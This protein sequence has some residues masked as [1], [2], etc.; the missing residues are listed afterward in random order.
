M[1]TGDIKKIDLSISSFERMITEGYLYVD[2]TR[3]IEH[4]LNFTSSVQLIARQRRLG[5]SLNMDMLRCF[6]T[7][8]KDYRHLFKGLYIESSPMWDKAHTGPVFSFDFKTL[9]AESYKAQIIGQTYKNISTI[10][11]PD[12]LKGYL[13]HQFDNLINNPDM[14]SDSLLILTEIAYK[15]TGKRSYLLIDEYD[16]LLMYHYDKEQYEE[17]RSFKAALLSAGLK[18]NQYLE[19]ALLTGVM[20]ISHESILSGLNNIVTFDVFRDEI[21]TEDYGLTEEEIKELNKKADFEIDEMRAWYNGVKVSGKEIYNTYSVMSYLAR[22]EYDCYWGKSG[23]LEMI[24]NLLND[25]RKLTLTKLLNG[26][27]L[28]IEMD[29]RISLQQLSSES[30]DGAFYSLLAQAGYLSIDE[31][32]L[33]GTALVSIPNREL[34]IVWKNFIVNRLYT[35]ASQARTLFD[36][37][38]NPEEFAKDI[39]YFLQDRLSYY[40]LAVYKGED[41][42]RVQERIYHIYL[43]GIL[44]AYEDIRCRYPLTNRESGAGRYDILV[45]KPN[46]NFIFELKSCSTEDELEKKAKEALEQIEAKRYGVD[47]GEAK[48]LVKIGIAFYDKMCK[49][50][51]G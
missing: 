46:A 37:A 48:R 29:N 5:K 4:F 41:R 13:K 7:D 8:T 36:N 30:G 9:T 6:L 31:K 21:Y 33:Q 47:I 3:M 23:T 15:V 2:K 25:H 38:D 19:K 43:L 45:E 17:I 51:C 32:H 40:D 28:K 14:A 18:G 24:I 50:K 10:V 1:I 16:K 11:D 35:N 42:E 22:G 39:E 27:Q 12:T 26:E 34:V 44:S 20:R 49:V